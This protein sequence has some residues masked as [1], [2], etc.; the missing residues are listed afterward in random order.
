MKT[1]LKDSVM[2]VVFAILLLVVL[3]LVGAHPLVSLGLPIGMYL[4]GVFLLVLR[5]E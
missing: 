1:A 2:F 5:G 4:T 3:V